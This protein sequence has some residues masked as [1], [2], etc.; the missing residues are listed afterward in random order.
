MRISFLVFLI[1]GVGLVACSRSGDSSAIPQVEVTRLYITATSEP[2]RTATASPTA[3]RSPT[4]TPSPTPTA[5]TIEIAGNPRAYTL[6]DPVPQSGAA[7][8]WADTLDF[9]LD[10]PDGAGASGGGDFGA[11][12]DRYE[13]YHAGEDWG[14]SNRNNFGQPVYSIG[15]G[16]VTYAQ[17]LGW[18]ADKGVVIIRHTFPDGNSILSFYGHLDPPSVTLREGTCVRRGDIVGQ[19]GRPRTP[20]HLHFEVRVHLPYATGGGYWP[21]DPTR[22]GWLPPSQTVSQYRM[23]VSPGVEWINPATPTTSQPLGR[24]DIDTFLLID[25]GQL[26]AINLFTGEQSWAAELST[27]IKAA[28]LDPERRLLYITD[29]VAGVRGYAL[30]AADEDIPEVLEPRWEQKLPSSGRMDLMPLPGGGVLV[31]YKGTLNAFSPQGDLLWRET[32]DSDLE[33]WA[34]TEESLIFTT[35]DPEMSLRSADMDGLSIWNESE[36]GQ[37]VAA[38]DRVWLY[39][40]EGL[41][42]LDLEKQ[43][44]QR[45]YDLP[46][47]IARQS[48]ALPLTNGG[49]LLLHSDPADRRLLLFDANGSLQWEFSV[50]HNGEPQLFE[51]DGQLFLLMQPGFSGRG[52]YKTAEVFAL[53]LQDNQLLRIFEGGSRTFNPRATWAVAVNDRELMINIG[54]GGSVLLDPQAALERMGQ[55]LSGGN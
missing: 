22:A 26:V 43:T 41:Y 42:K 28:Y 4:P 6:F 17:P 20:P 21:S 3:T 31:S 34:L 18:G 25:E 47:G 52:S 10:P 45:V 12:R 16:Q 11:Y 51:L 36:T 37:L 13:K 49:V 19:I 39:A 40:T 46:K 27:Y 48:A 8:G 33:N 23:Q 15:H 29:A 53:D 35:S 7:C 24:L 30:P 38:G 5:P 9:P 50:P 1:L 44:T 14:V 55:Q 2:T 54:G 32:Q